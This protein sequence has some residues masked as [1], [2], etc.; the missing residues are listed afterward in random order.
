MMVKAT[1]AEP[2]VGMTLPSVPRAGPASPSVTSASGFPSAISTG[3]GDATY[4][5]SG[6]NPD[7]QDLAERR[8]QR[9]CEGRLRLGGHPRSGPLA[10][11][12]V[13]WVAGASDA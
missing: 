8:R 4:S 11:W 9:R 7:D 3:T 1:L 12:D 2:C 10:A 13:A 6:P 5:W